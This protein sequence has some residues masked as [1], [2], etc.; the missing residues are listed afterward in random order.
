M[1]VQQKLSGFYKIVTG[2]AQKKREEI[3][4]QIR[5]KMKNDFEKD[6]EKTC[7][8]SI[9]KINN[10]KFKY[11]QVKNK[12]I[13]E[14]VSMARKNFLILRNELKNELFEQA[15]KKIFEF[16]KTQIYFEHIE[17]EL[18]AMNYENPVIEF[19]SSD[20]ELLKQM[21]KKFTFKIILSN[22]NF[23]GGYRIYLKNSKIVIDKSF[24]TR[25]ERAK[26]N[27]NKFKLPN[28]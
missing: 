20:N 25:L 17:S 8:H 11:E 3:F 4:E 16:T 10:K 28:I 2:E 18:K 26:E 7:R 21:E 27:F 15:E 13:V 1:D 24:K 6:F 5:N 12:E 23:L 9:E 14:T 22:E 19:S